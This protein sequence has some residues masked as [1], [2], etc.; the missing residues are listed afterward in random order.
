MLTFQWIFSS[1][2]TGITE[3]HLVQWLLMHISFPNTQRT[4]LH[5]D[6]SYL[7]ILGQLFIQYSHSF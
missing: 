4:L 7:L 5:M 1:L 2:A 6:S 3:V